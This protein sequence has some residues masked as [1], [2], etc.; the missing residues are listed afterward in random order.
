MVP[1]NAE[2][3][4]VLVDEHVATSPVTPFPVRVK[5]PETVAMIVEGPPSRLST[6]MSTGER[7]GVDDID[8][9]QGSQRRIEL[10]DSNRLRPVALPWWDRS[11]ILAR[12]AG[13][14]LMVLSVV[15]W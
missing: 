5:L 13:S 7:A 1:S 6:L 9:S 11:P 3:E 10:P 2:A 15:N 8:R 4:K 12:I 14:V